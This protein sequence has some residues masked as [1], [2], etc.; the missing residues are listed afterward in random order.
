MV[1]KISKQYSVGFGH[2]DY[3]EELSAK[4]LVK[5][6]SSDLKHIIRHNKCYM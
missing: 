3:F 6:I 4:F 5:L 2:Y 1:G